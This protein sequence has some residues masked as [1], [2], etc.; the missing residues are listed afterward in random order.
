MLVSV[1][2]EKLVFEEEDYAAAGELERGSGEKTKTEAE[3]IASLVKE[4]HLE[5]MMNAGLICSVEV[6]RRNLAAL[7][8]KKQC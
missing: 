4:D 2:S 6:R 3:S 8:P 7:I 5:R 1:V